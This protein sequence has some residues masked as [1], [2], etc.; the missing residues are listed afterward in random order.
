ML[1]EASATTTFGPY[2]TDVM[3][4]VWVVQACGLPDEWAVRVDGRLCVGRECAGVDEAHRMLLD[5][6]SISRDH[7]EIRVSGAD[8]RI[9]DR[10]TNSTR[11]N[12]RLIERDEWH[13]LADGDVIMIGTTKLTLQVLSDD[14]TLTPAQDATVSGPDGARRQ[15]RPR[16]HHSH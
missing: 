5:G 15:C 4:D 14:Q 1:P 9:V 16:L 8:V 12:R 6:A 10:S 2:D 3:P 7:A 11:V 13:P